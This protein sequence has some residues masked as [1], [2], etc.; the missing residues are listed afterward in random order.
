MIDS[1]TPQSAHRRTS[2]DGKPQVL[3]FSD[4]FNVDGRT[5]YPG[6]DPYWEAVDLHYWGTNNLEWYSPK[7][8]TTTEGK[9]AITL[10][11]RETHDLD[12]AG[13]MITSWN[14]F[15]YS[16]NA[17]LVASIALPGTSDVW[18][19]WPAFWTMGVSSKIF[20]THVAKVFAESRQ[21]RVRCF[22][23]GS[24]AILI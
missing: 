15:C 6:E 7:Q 24:L 19:L 1:D 3:V 16:N 4:E 9:L 14:K 13:G 23:R 2:F 18:G 22:S 21:S 11:E 17:Y 10:D 12:Y 20:T 8:I 5:F